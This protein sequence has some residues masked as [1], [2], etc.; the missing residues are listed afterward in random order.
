[1][2]EEDQASL[3]AARETEA[4]WELHAAR[5]KASDI[6]ER[7]PVRKGRAPRVLWREGPGVTEN[8]VAEEGWYWR[9]RAPRCRRFAG[10]YLNPVQSYEDGYY[11]DLLAHSPVPA[12]CLSEAVR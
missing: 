9:C 11:H 3:I 5:W 7:V 4:R 6:V 10:P 8:A 2:T 1:M 12:A